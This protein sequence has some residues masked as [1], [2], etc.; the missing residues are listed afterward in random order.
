MKDETAFE[1]TIMQMISSLGLERCR[2]F[3]SHFSKI[4]YTAKGEKMHM[5]FADAEYGPDFQHL[6]PSLIK[7][8]LNPTI[9][10]E[11]RG[12][13][14]DDAMIMKEIYSSFFRTGQ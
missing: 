5:T 6:A 10:C 13:Q 3:H 4:A 12:T 9:I 2:H 14:A 8:G 7:Y 1:Q 11:S